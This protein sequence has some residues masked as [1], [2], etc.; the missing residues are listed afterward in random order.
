VV[1]DRSGRLI[2]VLRREALMRALARGPAAQAALAEATVAGS[3]ARGY[4]AAVSGLFAACLAAL[5][6]VRPVGGGTDER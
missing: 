3:L 6:G 5:P 4:W 1:V 2:G